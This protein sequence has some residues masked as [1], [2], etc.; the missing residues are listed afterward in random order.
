[1][2]EREGWARIQD[3]PAEIGEIYSGWDHRAARRIEHLLPA[4][5][6]P[7]DLEAAIKSG[8]LDIGIGDPWSPDCIALACEGIV[9]DRAAA[10]QYVLANLLLREPTAADDEA[11]YR[12]GEPGRPGSWWLC[13]REC[14]RRWAEEERHSSKAG[15]ESPADWARELAVWLQTEHPA[16]PPLTH[17][18][19]TNK[20]SPLLRELRANSPK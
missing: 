13:K 6:K 16:A 15:I 12:T 1:M 10:R 9:Y 11:V 2:T 14:R 8:F 4:G 19:L 20:L 17:K 18:T 7:E 3:G 5:A